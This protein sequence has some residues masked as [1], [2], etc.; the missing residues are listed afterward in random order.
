MFVKLAPDLTDDALSEAIGVA[1]TGGAAGIIATN[2]TIERTGLTDAQAHQVGA[3]GLSG[4]P[5]QPRSLEV[6]RFVA[7]NTTLPVIGVGGISTVDHVIAA[8]DAG[9]KAVQV[10]SAMIYQGP[11]LVHRLNKGLL[12]HLDRVGADSVAALTAA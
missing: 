11:S 1:E 5:L 2:T 10:Y 7:S 12:Q 8:L 6:I 9:A 4:A 3:G